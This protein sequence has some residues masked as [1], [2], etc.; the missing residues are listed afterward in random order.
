MKLVL[1]VIIERICAT[2][3]DQ[4]HYLQEISEYYFRMDGKM[5]R[6][7]FLIQLS[8]YLYEC[9]YQRHLFDSN[10]QSKYLNQ[11]NFNLPDFL[12]SN[13]FHNKIIPYAACIE[14]LH[15]ASLLQDDIIDNSSTRRSKS[16]AHSLF[17]V[18]NTIFS[19]NFILSKAASV[20]TDLDIYL[21][22]EIYSNIVFD[23]TYGE[24][25][26]TINKP[27]KYSTLEEDVLGNLD[28]YMIKTYYKTASLIALSF[29][30]LGL[31]FNLDLNEQK[32]LFSLGLQLG[33]LFQIIDDIIDVESSSSTLKKPSFKDI[34]EGVVNSHVIYEMFDSNKDE[35]LELVKL[36]FKDPKDVERIKQILQNGLGVL[37]SNN[38]ALDHLLETLEILNNPFFVNSDTKQ[39]LIKSIIFMFNRNY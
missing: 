30:G 1:K 36:K 8:K 24:Y 33:V 32:L 6:P 38:L 27:F 9:T 5:I 25:Q 16:T 37:K 35:V 39:K 19:S 13:I 34:I 18:R 4:E 20:I 12:D 15:N 11:S 22:N 17:G 26:Q 28:R 31:I 23:L 2:T 10:Q 29:R 14:A 21:L 3:V 7:H